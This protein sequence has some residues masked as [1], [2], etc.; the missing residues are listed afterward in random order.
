LM[1][2][3]DDSGGELV[4]VTPNIALDPRARLIY[5]T[6]ESLVPEDILATT[7]SK[8]LE[9]NRVRHAVVAGYVAILFGRTRRSDDVDFLIEPLDE[10]CFIK[11]AKEIA[12]AG[13]KLMQGDIY[14][15]TSVQKVFENYLRQGYGIRLMLDEQILPNIELKIAETTIQNYAIA[16]SYKVIINSEHHVR[17]SPLELQ[18]AYKLYLGSDKDVGDAIFLYTLFRDVLDS[19]ELRK[20]CTALHTDCSALEAVQ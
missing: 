3:R 8:V 19:D 1:I 18:I 7:L 15:E 20:W 13:F 6:K 17:I 16:N 5:L 9:N 2:S 14:S 10:S 12:S 4:Y 11:L